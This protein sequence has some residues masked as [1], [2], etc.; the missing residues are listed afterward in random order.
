MKC[1]NEIKAGR[2]CW[3]LD[4]AVPLD[5]RWGVSS[6]RKRKGRKMPN[7]IGHFGR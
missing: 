7:G 5:I 2:Q 6:E 3:I 1:D 4:I